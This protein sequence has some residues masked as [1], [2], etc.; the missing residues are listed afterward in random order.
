MVK[1]EPGAADLV[2]IYEVLNET[3]GELFVGTT[4]RLKDLTGFQQMTPPK[5]VRH[6]ELSDTLVFRTIEYGIPNA[7][8]PAFIDAYRRSDLV[9]RFKVLTER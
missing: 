9:K 5:I 4:W 8:A 3:K 6:W 1:D 7:D 2:S